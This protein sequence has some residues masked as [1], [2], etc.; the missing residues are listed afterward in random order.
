M[1]FQL[2]YT[3][4]DCFVNAVIIFIIYFLIRTSLKNHLDERSLLVKYFNYYIIIIGLIMFLYMNVEV[5]WDLNEISNYYG[6]K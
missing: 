3:F 4:L 1:N 6:F 5:V 2:F